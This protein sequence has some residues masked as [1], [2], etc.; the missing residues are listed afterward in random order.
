MKK[1][2]LFAF[3]L[4]VILG[5]SQKRVSIYNFS[6]YQM[7]IYNLRTKPSTSATYPY[8]LGFERGLFPNEEALLVNTNSTTKFPFYSPTTTP[9]S[10]GANGYIWKRYTSA[11]NS[12]LINGLTLWNSAAPA[13]QVL[14]G[15]F[16]SVGSITGD[17]NLSLYFAIPNNGVATTYFA[18]SYRIDYER[19]YITPTNY[20]DII[21]FSNL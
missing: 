7:K 21:I 12:S 11:T 15:I 3:L 9:A 17:S 6:T 19:F 14:A 4:T 13:T 8:Y 16:Y 18:T 20:E 10:I 1:L 5:F 2:F